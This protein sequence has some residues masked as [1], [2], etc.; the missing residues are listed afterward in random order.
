MDAPATPRSWFMSRQEFEGY[1]TKIMVW[2][3]ISVNYKSPLMKIDGMIDQCKYQQ[4]LQDSGV[5]TDMNQLYGPGGWLFMDDGAPSHRA[6]ST[7]AFLSLQCRVLPKDLSWPPHSPDLNTIENGWGIIKGRAD[8]RDAKD[9]DEL[10][11]RA[12]VV[13]SGIDLNPLAESFA[14]RVRACNAIDGA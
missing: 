5:F 13:W 10:Y 11:E 2:G 8:T 12:K 9:S 3:G 7:Q 6:K 14:A 1:P 4:M